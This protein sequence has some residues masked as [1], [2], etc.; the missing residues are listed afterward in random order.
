ME[1]ATY[2]GGVPMTIW[3]CY[4]SDVPELMGVEQGE[5]TVHTQGAGTLVLIPSTKNMHFTRWCCLILCLRSFFSLV[6]SFFNEGRGKEQLFKLI[7]LDETSM[8]V[9]PLAWQTS[10]ERICISKKYTLESHFFWSKKTKH[11][12]LELYDQTAPGNLDNHQF[13]EWE[14]VPPSFPLQVNADRRPAQLYPCTGK[15]MEY[16]PNKVGFCVVTEDDTKTCTL[17][18]ECNLKQCAWRFVP[19]Q[20]IL[21]CIASRVVAEVSGVRNKW[22]TK[23]FDFYHRCDVGIFS[24]GHRRLFQCG[25]SHA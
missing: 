23:C 18:W 5:S 3:C 1:D 7:F 10:L 8:L 12:S 13:F 6:A 16:T 4:F 9:H 19:Y 2:F 22:K 15:R 14:V 20:C 11:G 17:N 21:Q 24:A 25:T